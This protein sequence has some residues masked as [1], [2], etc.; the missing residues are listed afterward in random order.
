MSWKK[1]QIPKTIPNLNHPILIEGLPGIGNV[2]KIVVD[3]MIDELKAKK[4][5]EFYSNTFPHSVFVNEKNLVE[6]PKIEMYYKKSQ[7]GQDF[8][9]LAGDIQ[10]VKEVPSYE[11]S[12]LIIGILKEFK[13]KEIITLGGIGLPHVPDEM[14]VYATGNDEKIIKKYKTKTNL[15]SH[16]YG[17]VGPIIGVTGLLLG[18]SKKE[19]IPAICMLSET[20]GHPMY[21]GIKGSR[22]ILK[23]LNKKLKLKLKLEKLDKEI[24]DLEAEMKKTDDFAMVL[25]NPDNK[26]N[27]NR[28]TDYIG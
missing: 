6:L 28:P 23:I 27:P 18:L 21:L 25:S 14:K 11:F 22:E 9:F 13:G 10:P 15:D 7:K 5:F 20:Y 2:G 19:N 16:L 4:L 26:L 1:E 24:K 8:L 3:F 17:T 12:K